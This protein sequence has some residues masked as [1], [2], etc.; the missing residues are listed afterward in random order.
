MEFVLGRFSHFNIAIAYS[1]FTFCGAWTP[2]FCEFT[3]K[4]SKFQENEHTPGRVV[5]KIT[6]LRVGPTCYWR[7]GECCVK[8][9]AKVK[10]FLDVWSLFFDLSRSLLL[11]LMDPEQ[12]KPSLRSTVFF[13]C[14][15]RSWRKCLKS[16]DNNATFPSPMTT[17]CLQNW[18]SSLCWC[19]L[20]TTYTSI[21]TMWQLLVAMHARA[22]PW[23][24]VISWRPVW[25]YVF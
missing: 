2:S 9:N 10:I 19:L 15:L 7:L 16:I 20:S 4:Q 3:W 11:L 24:D 8:T 22:F 18:F 25:R 1:N 12:V 23:P 6:G 14:H 13:K 17:W 5:S 21:A